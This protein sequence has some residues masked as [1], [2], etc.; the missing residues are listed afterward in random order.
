MAVEAGADALGFI[1]FE[2]SKR[3]VSPDA[4]RAIIEQLPPFISRV[5]V[6]VNASFDSVEEIIEQTGISV[7]QFHGDEPPEF[8]SRFSLSV[9]K[10]FAIKD[11]SSIGAF[12]RYK[13]SAFLLDTWSPAER[14]GTGETFNWDLAKGAIQ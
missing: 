4:A 2:Q 10:A 6:F 9:I 7:L 5:G 12:G 14:G 8:C 11:S 3:H 1:F 13:T